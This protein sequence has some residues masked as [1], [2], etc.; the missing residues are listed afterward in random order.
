MKKNTLVAVVVA[1]CIVAVIVIYLRRTAPLGMPAR[2][3]AADDRAFFPVVHELL[4]S[5]E[6]SVDVILYQGRYYF[7]YPMSASNTLLTDLVDAAERGVRVKVVL[8]RADWNLDNTEENRDVWH[9]LTQGDMELYFDPVGT[10][11]HSKLVIV[12]DRYVVMGSTNWSHYSI[13]NNNEAN[14]VID[15]EEVG[16]QLKTYFEGIVAQ[17]E[18]EY[19]PP[20]EPIT[21]SE[22]EGWEGRYVLIRDVADSAVYDPLSVMGRLYFGDVLVGVVD[23]PLEEILTVDSLFF[24]KAETTTDHDAH[25]FTPH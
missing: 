22:V 18:T 20:I 11:S 4:T 19:V 2:V 3:A 1:L 13:D 21:A 6:N 14:V 8:E 10:T 15:S 23:R 5:A 7:H 16:K 9:V 25:G 17:S 12:D 24:A